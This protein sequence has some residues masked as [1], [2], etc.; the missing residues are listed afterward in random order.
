MKEIKER[1]KYINNLINEGNLDEEL[2]SSLSNELDELLESL[3]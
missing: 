1:I 2:L 3:S